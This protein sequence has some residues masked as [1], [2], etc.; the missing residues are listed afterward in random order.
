MALDTEFPA[1]L[2]PLE[3]DDSTL[4]SPPANLEAEQ[5]LLAAIL[6]N[7][8]AMEKVSEFLEAEH[9]ADPV[10]ARIFEACAK[11][12]T[13]GQLA[14]AVTLKNLFDQDGD[15]DD[16]GGSQYLAQL[17]GTYV[18]II[19]VR[20]YGEII[21][22]LYLRRQLIN[23]G[24][25]VVNEAF[26]IDLD[27]PATDQIEG[28]EQKLYT[29]AESG[30][31]G[32]DFKTFKS[33]LTAAVETAEMAYKRDGGLAG[34]ATALDDLDRMIG[35]LH[36]SDLIILAG[37][38]SMGKT[39]LAT[40]IAFNVTK[41][42]RE[43]RAPDGTIVEEPETVAFFSLEMSAE[44]LAGRIL[45]EQSGIRSDSIRKGEMDQ[46]QFDQLFQ[47]SRELENLRLFIDDTPGIT[48][49]AMR[50]RCRRLKRQ[51]GLSLIVVDYLQLMTTPASS[52]SDSR[53]QEVS[54]ITRG[55]KG[56]A[57]ELDVP[58][59][60]LSQLSRQVESREDKRP[61]LSDLRESGSIEQD[62]DM[63]WFVFREQYYVERAEPLRKD[64]ETTD[65]FNERHAAWQQRCEEVFGLAEVILAKQRHGPIGSVKLLFDGNTTRFSSYADPDRYPNE[66]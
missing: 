46:E 48:V 24:E 62:A 8:Y 9:F 22:D 5:A 58:V 31:S 51:F 57:K 19:D 36:K 54:E 2:S 66:H 53:V 33:A 39:A 63:V 52:R 7:N 20:H 4:R 38:P 47:A 17:Q 37:R 12:I 64:N 49:P 34:V 29:L 45:A 25:E 14:T 21:H 27:I 35:G 43:E 59:I 3:E 11:L 50:T 44:Q 6:A 56:I 65:S 42:T 16:I 26:Q 23:L 13:R 55:L 28:A 32:G 30:S 40:N 1:D 18:N 15:L 60:A 61:M 41:E 10:H